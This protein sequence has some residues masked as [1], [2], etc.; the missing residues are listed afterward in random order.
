MMLGFTSKLVVCGPS[1]LDKIVYIKN[2][3][4]L[5]NIFSKAIFLN[6]ATCEDRFVSNIPRIC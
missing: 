3:V 2:C 6:L 4:G 5:S 1:V